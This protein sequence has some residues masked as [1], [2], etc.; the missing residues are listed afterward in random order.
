LLYQTALSYWTSSELRDILSCQSDVS[1]VCVL[2]ES[3]EFARDDLVIAVMEECNFSC[4]FAPFPKEKIYI[5][6][7]NSVFMSMNILSVIM[8][9]FSQYFWLALAELARRDRIK[10]LRALSSEGPS[11]K[12]DHVY[13]LSFSAPQW[14]SSE[15]GAED[16]REVHTTLSDRHGKETLGA[17]DGACSSSSSRGGGRDLHVALTILPPVV[18]STAP[19][20]S[21]SSSS[22]DDL[23]I[24]LFPSRNALSIPRY[25]GVSPALNQLTLL[26]AKL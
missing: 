6:V 20:V 17:V 3:S 5:E 15:I 21:T 16:L 26:I 8:R 9:S 2:R 10:L 11:R 14:M 25:S 7:R 4:T 12:H 1:N 18:R 24:T 23:P 22:D 19:S 13:Y